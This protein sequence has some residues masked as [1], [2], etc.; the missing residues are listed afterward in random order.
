M[1]DKISSSD[2]KQIKKLI[3]KIDNDSF[4]S[5]SSER[6][7][8]T[9]SSQKFCKKQPGCLPLYECPKSCNGCDNCSNSF[10]LSSSECA[11]ECSK[12]SSNGSCCFNDCQDKV[13]INVMPAN[14]ARNPGASLIFYSIVT[15]A[16]NLSS[17]NLDCIEFMMRRKNKTITL[18]W[19]EFKGVISANGVSN[20]TVCNSI[21]NL[22]PYQVN[23]PIF[24]NYKGV[25][26]ITHLTIDPY[27][28]FG[29]GNIYFFLNSEGN[30]TGISSG[31]SFEIFGGSVTW[32]SEV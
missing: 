7:S 29:Q 27:S 11:K 16:T 4:S 31:D 32:I 2:M 25:G 6:S 8:C 15:P 14:S 9:E 24:I 28:Q 30:G 13:R 22:P 1:C 19:R 17:G 12:D 23:F 20:L 26:R 18:Q 10:T 21:S 3:K 5:L